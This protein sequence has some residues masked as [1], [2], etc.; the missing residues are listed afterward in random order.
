MT[1]VARVPVSIGSTGRLSVLSASL[2]AALAA[3]T[4]SYEF[5]PP[6]FF[7]GGVVIALLGT[8]GHGYARGG[9]RWLLW[10]YA[11]LVL[12]LVLAFGIAGG[13]WDHGV[14][15]LVCMLHGGVVPPVLQPMFTSPELGGAPYEIAW[16]LTFLASLAAFFF[17]HRFIR[18]RAVIEGSQP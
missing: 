16:I 17:G 12:W 5:G 8:L 4:H 2:T 13:F 11:L 6:A 3:Y 18:S 14:K 9:R 15:A 1:T 7:A 10:P